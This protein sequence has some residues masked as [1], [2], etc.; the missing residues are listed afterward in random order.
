[1]TYESNGDLLYYE[2]GTKYPQ[3]TLPAY[4]I[5]RAQ[6]SDFELKVISGFKQCFE[7]RNDPRYKRHQADKIKQARKTRKINKQFKLQLDLEFLNKFSKVC[8]INIEKR[9]RD[10]AELIRK[11]QEENLIKITSHGFCPLT[12]FR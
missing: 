11:E 4:L 9:K 12:S 2:Y 7:S 10:Q 5:Y 8:Y 3:K 6:K 1:M